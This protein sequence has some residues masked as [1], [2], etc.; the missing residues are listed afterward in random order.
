MLNQEQ[1]GFFK[2]NGYLIVPGLLDTELCGKVS[3]MMWS[4][5]PTS[6]SIKKSEI[7]SHVGPFLQE[8]IS[9]DSIHFR[10]GYRWLNRALGSSSEVIDLIY[11]DAVLSIAQQLLGGQLRQ[12]VREGKPMG[13]E[14]PVWPGGPTDPATGTEAARGVYCTLPYG[15]KPR[16]P[17]QCHTYGH[18]LQLG[19][20]QSLI[21]I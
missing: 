7:S 5:L 20:V 11:S 12:I 16:E 13:S 14:G 1:L 4:S 2:D 19:I 6:S 15:D 21:H 10:S 18:P 17:D 8:D 3:D 9:E